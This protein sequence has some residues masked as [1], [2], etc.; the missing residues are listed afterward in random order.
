MWS[1]DP[2][3]LSDHYST[4]WI[5][6]QNN[7]SVPVQFDKNNFA[8]LD[9][10]RNQLDSV[11]PELVLEAMLQDESLYIDRFMMSLQ[12]QQDR[13]QKRLMIQQNIQKESFS[14]GEILPRASKQGFIFFPKIP[15]ENKSITFV[16][17]NKE[18][19]FQRLK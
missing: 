14:F 3:F 10:N 6:I 2:Q 18:I 13:S 9:Q 19:T 4:F 12:T 7:S 8:L 15:Y 1:K 5:K 17:K 16:F 11:L